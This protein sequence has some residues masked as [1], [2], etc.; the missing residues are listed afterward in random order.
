MIA[1]RL[2]RRIAS[3]DTPSY[4]DESINSCVTADRNMLTRVVETII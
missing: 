3:D 2:S 4:H 1:G